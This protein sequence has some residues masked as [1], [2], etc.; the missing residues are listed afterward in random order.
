MSMHQEQP[1]RFTKDSSE[2]IAKM[3]SIAA[4]VDDIIREILC[5]ETKSPSQ[6][7]VQR[8][9]QQLYDQA[10][11]YLGAGGKRMRPFTT[12]M[13]GHLFG[14]IDKSLY[15]AGATVELLHNF[16]L[17]HD[18][19]V[20]EDTVRRGV[21]TAH[22]A[23]G[24]P[25]ALNAG[26]YLHA[27]VYFIA[28]ELEQVTNGKGF[29]RALSIAAR[30][31]SEGQNLDMSFEGINDV[32][33]EEYLHMIESKTAALYECAAEL[34]GLVGGMR[35]ISRLTA[36]S[37]QVSALRTFGKNLG[38]G[39]QMRDDYLGAFG[40]SSKTQ[41]PVGSDLKRGKKTYIVIRALSSASTSQLRRIN[42]VLGNA[43]ASESQMQDALLVLR[44]L[45]VDDDCQ[46]LSQQYAQAAVSAL[47][48]FNDSEAKKSLTLM[49]DYAVTREN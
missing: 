17:I 21:K 33:V 43:S 3:Q 24:L 15:L 6:S 11:Y 38:L 45:G 14:D 41:K 2:L 47:A 32:T 13:A 12:V 49:A 4:E 42:T 25:N 26:N 1:L 48:A 40:D 46:I 31:I 18:D 8:L 30:K 9:D 23:F 27:T 20:D 16:T 7:R 5:Q 34:G 19:I 28:S 10:Y 22:E 37:H 29:H 39:F 44:E 36:D 35:N